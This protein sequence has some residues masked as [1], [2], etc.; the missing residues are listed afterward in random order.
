MKICVGNEIYREGGGGNNLFVIPKNILD[1]RL[2]VI[3]KCVCM[4]VYAII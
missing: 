1:P 2:F 3:R 4:S